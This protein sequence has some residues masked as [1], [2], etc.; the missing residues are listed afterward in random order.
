MSENIDIED[1]D[2]EEF[3]KIMEKNTLLTYLNH[4]KSNFYIT[5][6]QE[7]IKNIL[8]KLLKYFF[9]ISGG[10][11]DIKDN[12]P[13]YNSLKNSSQKFITEKQWEKRIIQILD[14][15]N[16]TNVNNSNLSLHPSI[17][18]L[19]IRRLKNMESCYI[20]MHGI[21]KEYGNQYIISTRSIPS[22]SYEFFQI[23][24]KEFV[25]NM[26]S[27][28]AI[29]C[30]ILR[31]PREVPSSRS[32]FP[33]INYLIHMTRDRIPHLRKCP[34]EYFCLTMNSVLFIYIDKTS[35]SIIEKLKKIFKKDEDGI[36]KYNDSNESEN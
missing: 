3:I 28:T 5:F 7:N 13:E 29:L 26:R 10:R 2:I 32:Y 25:D 23:T 19:K 33:L 12:T 18:R 15:A 17:R 31:I 30:K 24:L 27:N 22:N 11:E 4:K 34:D 20:Y 35:F 9:R 14:S 6:S 8:D 1:I 21:D 36:Y 16:S